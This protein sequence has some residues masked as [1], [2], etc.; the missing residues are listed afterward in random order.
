MR[1][2]STFTPGRPSHARALHDRERSDASGSPRLPIGA[3]GRRRPGTTEATPSE[4]GPLETVPDPA[5]A[6]GSDPVE[7]PPGDVPWLL[8]PAPVEAHRPM[9]SLT[10]SRREPLNFEVRVVDERARHFRMDLP[11]RWSR[12]ELTALIEGPDG[13]GR[14]AR[15]GIDKVWLQNGELHAVGRRAEQTLAQ[16]RAALIVLRTL[17]VGSP[18]Q[19]GFLAL[20]R[21]VPALMAVPKALHMVLQGEDDRVTF[22]GDRDWF[23][24]LLAQLTVECPSLAC[25]LFGHLAPGLQ[26]SLLRRSPSVVNALV[27]SLS[28]PKDQQA[29]CGCFESGLTQALRSGGG[30]GRLL[31]WL[32][33]CPPWAAG[34][35]LR[36]WDSH[37]VDSDK[38]WWLHESA[39]LAEAVAALGDAARPAMPDGPPQA[40]PLVVMGQTASPLRSAEEVLDALRA[41]GYPWEGSPE[42]S[43][44]MALVRQQV[45]QIV[46]AEPTEVAH[47]SYGCIIETLNLLKCDD[48]GAVLLHTVVNEVALRYQRKEVQDARLDWLFDRLARSFE[49]GFAQATACAFHRFCETPDVPWLYLQ[50]NRSGAYAVVQCADTVHLRWILACMVRHAG[51]HPAFQARGLLGLSQL[52]EL[53][54]LV[55]PEVPLLQVLAPQGLAAAHWRVQYLLRREFVQALALQA[56]LAPDDL[57]LQRDVLASALLGAAS[58]HEVPIRPDEVAMFASAVSSADGS[59]AFI[60]WMTGLLLRYPLDRDYQKLVATVVLNAVGRL[61]LRTDDRKAEKLADDLIAMLCREDVPVAFDRHLADKAVKESPAWTEKTL[62][63][64]IKRSQGVL[65]LGRSREAQRACAW[66]VQW[67]VG[68]D[69]HSRS[70]DRRKLVGFVRYLRGKG[71]L[72][73]LSVAE[74]GAVAIWLG[75][76][77][78]IW[79]TNGPG[80]AAGH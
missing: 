54:A 72:A 21:R 75:S 53:R 16:F 20:L 57:N 49:R 43:E 37:P 42:W 74:R 58:D 8:D 12:T 80:G 7:L 30:A 14:P 27:T 63:R 1:K 33:H 32:E 40:E 28:D 71:D 67:M 5:R 76:H 15:Q 38:R 36:I 3:V 52:G 65:G 29:L 6:T 56:S 45:G 66:M 68:L 13:S 2:D 77:E 23:A 22:H 41:H 55:G 10:L 34:P 11:E 31:G 62:V 48:P 78:G 79:P 24:C 59:P 17:G 73:L 60:A 64:W 50:G 70:E 26:C 9:A 69:P 19:P 18:D 44:G 51:G 4:P 35:L 47:A 61:C 25:R 39:A 46:G